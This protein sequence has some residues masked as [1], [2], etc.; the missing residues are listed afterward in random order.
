MGFAG[1]GDVVAKRVTRV[2][3][4]G[5]DRLMDL[6][7]FRLRVEAVAAAGA[8]PEVQEFLA[9]WQRADRGMDD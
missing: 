2:S 3:P 6:E 4:K 8:N 9:A 5:M 1:L 7:A